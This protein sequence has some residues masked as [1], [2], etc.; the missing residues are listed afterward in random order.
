MWEEEGG[1][2]RREGGAVYTGDS[3]VIGAVLKRVGEWQR[4]VAVDY[5]TG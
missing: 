5:R 4:V 3:G 1:G 2:G